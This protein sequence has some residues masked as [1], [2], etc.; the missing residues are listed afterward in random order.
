MRMLQ[1]GGELDG[2][3]LE[4]A[5]A[6]PVERTWTRL[7]F[8]A[9]VDGATADAGGRAQGLSSPGDQRVFHLLRSLA[10]V[11]VVGAGTARAEDYAPVLPREVDAALR[12]RLGLAPLPP[13][14]VVSAALDL[15]GGLLAGQP[16]T[17]PTLVVTSAGAPPDRIAAVRE[18]AEVLVCGDGAV[19]HRAV[20]DELAARGLH[21]ILCEGGPGLVGALASAGMV[22]EV[23]VTVSPQLL[24]GDSYRLA[25]GPQVD[26]S[27]RL[28]LGHAIVDGDQLLLRYVRAEER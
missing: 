16:G 24:V 3:D 1:A 17:A 18:H 26:P 22:D 9:T 15:P 25:R 19:D 23:C 12:Q 27:L 7:N 11:I 14:A 21:R 6:Y 8:V 20:R 28:Q 2:D 13:I 10:D 5:Y 4:A